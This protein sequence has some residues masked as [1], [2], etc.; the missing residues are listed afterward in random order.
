MSSLEKFI[1]S[2]SVYS[3]T[4]GRPVAAT[5]EDIKYV[6]IEGWPMTVKTYSLLTLK[7]VFG[8]GAR[9]CVEE[10]EALHAETRLLC[11]GLSL[12]PMKGH[13]AFALVKLFRNIMNISA[14]SMYDQQKITAWIALLD[15]KIQNEADNTETGT[16]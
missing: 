16:S 1:K 15:E 3:K 7:S 13:E 8:G 12:V 5:H 11:D 6:F 14:S 2:W 10:W 9:L 4:A